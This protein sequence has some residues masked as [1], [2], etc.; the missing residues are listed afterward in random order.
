MEFIDGGY[1][2][3]IAISGR[4]LKIE[5]WTRKEWLGA[6]AFGM[7]YKEICRETHAIRAVKEVRKSSARSNELGIL[8]QLRAVR[9]PN[10]RKLLGITNM[11]R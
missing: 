10:N 1:G 4:P 6:G 11:V 8:T 7:V 5:T 9:N 2:H 3:T